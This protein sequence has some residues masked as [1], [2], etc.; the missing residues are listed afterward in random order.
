MWAPDTKGIRELNEGVLNRYFQTFW[1][2]PP[3]LLT[4]ASISYL[5]PKSKR[6]SS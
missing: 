3:D 4:A 2:Y 5:F 6:M 1:M